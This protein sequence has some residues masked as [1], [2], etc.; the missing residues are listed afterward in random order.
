MKAFSKTFFYKRLLF[1]G[2]NTEQESLQL[3]LRLRTSLT[4]QTNNSPSSGLFKL[5]IFNNYLSQEEAKCPYCL[6]KL[7]KPPTRKRK[8][9]YCKETM[10]GRTLPIIKKKSSGY[11]KQRVKVDQYTLI[12]NELEMY[13]KEYIEKYHKIKKDL[14]SKRKRV[15]EDRDVF[16]Q[17]INFIE[18][19]W[20][21]QSHGD[22]IVMQR[23]E[24][25]NF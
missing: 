18:L 3:R 17:L 11:R 21:V 9:P 12:V 16:W 15:R 22:Y 2:S 4:I 8:C 1:L 24:W 13:G 6:D 19:I 25:L 5:D 14:H 23:I 7:E 10:S 20:Q